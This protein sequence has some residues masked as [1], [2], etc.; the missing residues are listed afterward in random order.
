MSVFQSTTF[1]V[2]RDA[3]YLTEACHEIAAGNQIYPIGVAN[4]LAKNAEL[5]A[6]LPLSA[7][8]ATAIAG[9][10]DPHA[11]AE[12]NPAKHFKFTK[13][14]CNIGIIGHVDIGKSG[15]ALAAYLARARPV[16]VSIND[17]ES[18]W[19]ALAADKLEK[20]ALPPLDRQPSFITHYAGQF[21]EKLADAASLR[22]IEAGAG[23]TDLEAARK[24]LFGSNE[25]LNPQDTFQKLKDPKHWDRFMFSHEEE[26]IRPLNAPLSGAQQAANKAAHAA[27]LAAAPTIAARLPG[28]IKAAALELKAQGSAVV[29]EAFENIYTGTKIGGSKQPG[30]DE[31]LR[32]VVEYAQP[33]VDYRPYNGLLPSVRDRAKTEGLGF[34]TSLP[35]APHAQP[36]PEPQRKHGSMA[37]D[38]KLL[39]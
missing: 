28:I 18:V 30:V 8:Q 38:L 25:Q 35:L 4:C 39:G 29:A 19:K 27:A 22:W 3:I 15:A 10:H 14:K 20:P 33:D 21:Q 12:Q 36:K 17:V 32:I 6:K 26:H 9:Y 34:I 23:S 16:V 1:R 13:P 11:P 31:A 2:L 24:L 7:E 37:A 5:R